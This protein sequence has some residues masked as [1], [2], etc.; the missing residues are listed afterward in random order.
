MNTIKTKYPDFHR[1]G[2]G[3]GFTL[4]E[5]LVVIA[6][7]GIL[8]A[9][10]LPAL[11]RAREAARRASCQNNLKQIGLIMKMYANEARGAFPPMKSRG[12]DGT[13]HPMEQMCDVTVM[14]PEYLTDFS[15]LI[16]PSAPAGQTPEER[17]DQ[18]KTTSPY[19]YAW[20]GS[21]N[22]TVEPCEV[23]DYP[24]TYIGWVITSDMVDEP[25]KLAALETNVF[26]PVSGLGARITAEPEKAVRDDWR[27][28]VSG[29]GNGVGDLI[30]RLREG[31]ERFLI[32]DINNPAGAAMAQS[33]MPIFWDI[34]CDE[35]THFNHVPGGSNILF[36]DG[37]VE[38]V[39]WPGRR[40]P[41][42]TWTNFEGIELP[43]GGTFPMN[44]GGIT[45]HAA[46]HYFGGIAN[47]H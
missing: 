26:D 11:A 19:W 21:N 1:T 14:Y 17:W 8:A 25:S 5:L 45:F 3:K 31:I 29:S 44:A 43:V 13:P 39:R 24:Y 35:P 47:P 32:T 33:N 36:M 20:S 6:I 15:I 38:F 37:H 9:I 16:C 41:G 28:V 42:G 2:Y 7:I 10:L 46:S 23:A 12:C 30:Y 27:V 40:G 22:E 34:V 4:I 18:G